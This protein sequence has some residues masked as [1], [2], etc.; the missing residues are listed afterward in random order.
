MKIRLPKKVIAIVLSVIIVSSVA[1]SLAA[2]HESAYSGVEILGNSTLHQRYA[3][4]V[5][6]SY[7]ENYSAF[8]NSSTKQGGL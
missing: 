7:A 8:M 6:L 3:P 4:V 1:I 5:N 2:L